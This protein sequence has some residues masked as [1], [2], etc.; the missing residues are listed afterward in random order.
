MDSDYSGSSSEDI[1]A[2]RSDR[3]QKKSRANKLAPVTI[4]KR[5]EKALNNTK[6]QNIEDQK[7]LVNHDITEGLYERLEQLAISKEEEKQ[8]RL[9]FDLYGPDDDSGVDSVYPFSDSSSFSSLCASGDEFSDSDDYRP[10]SQEDINDHFNGGYDYSL[11]DE[12]ELSSDC[13][14]SSLSSSR[15]GM[16]VKKD[17]KDIGN[18]KNH[19]NQLS[20]QKDK[21]ALT[22]KKVLAFAFH[23]LSKKGGHHSRQVYNISRLEKQK[24]A[25]YQEKLNPTTVPEQPK[26]RGRGYYKK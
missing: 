13:S 26:E 19:R 6:K 4:S 7:T 14:H 8:N 23:G 17:E 18:D 20:H 24:I 2:I 3:F 22:D 12:S 1:K 11:E 16:S 21:H 5:L 15:E 10:Y 9:D 25:A